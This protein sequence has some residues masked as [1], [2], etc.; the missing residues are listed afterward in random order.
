MAHVGVA[1]A[2]VGNASVV[3]CTVNSTDF[4]LT[5]LGVGDYQLTTAVTL[6]PRRHRDSQSVYVIAVTCS[7][8]GLPPLSDF[9]FLSVSLVGE[10]VGPPRF[11]AGVI[12]A[13]VPAGARPDTPV[14]RLNASST[15]TGTGSVEAEVVYSMRLVSGRLDALK[16]DARSGWVRTK[17]YVAPDVIN[18][19]LTY[20]VTARDQRTPALS[21]TASLRVHVTDD[22]TAGSSWSTLSPV[23]DGAVV[24]SDVIIASVVCATLIVLALIAVAGVV[25]CVRRRRWCAVKHTSRHSSGQHLPTLLWGRFF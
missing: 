22:V 8:R 12:S 10:E 7:D 6:S 11:V 1:D 4:L 15:A 24:H 17:V 23:G 14:I 21:A 25:L 3:D 20:H 5:P 9:R 19:T 2:D 16:V 13:T 18:T